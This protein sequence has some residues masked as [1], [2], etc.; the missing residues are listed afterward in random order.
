MRHRPSRCWSRAASHATSTAHWLSS[1]RNMDWT[2]SLRDRTVSVHW[3]LTRPPCGIDQMLIHGFIG[4]AF[5][6]EIGCLHTTYFPL[7]HVDIPVIVEH[8][9]SGDSIGNAE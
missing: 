8:V 3:G 9:F 7:R 1:P 2:S 6:G 4:S 5:D